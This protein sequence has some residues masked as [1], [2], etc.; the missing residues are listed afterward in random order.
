MPGEKNG[1]L[2]HGARFVLAID[3]ISLSGSRHPET[4]LCRLKSELLAIE[5]IRGESG[6]GKPSIPLSPD[7]S[8]QTGRKS[9]GHSVGIGDAVFHASMVMQAYSDGGRVQLRVRSVGLRRELAAGAIE[10]KLDTIPSHRAW[11]CLGRQ[12]GRPRLYLFMRLQ[13]Q[14]TLGTF[15]A[16][17][18][19]MKPAP[20]QQASLSEFLGAKGGA[21]SK[22][23]T[24]DKE[25]SGSKTEAGG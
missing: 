21:K 10:F 19:T 14:Q 6:S 15:F 9:T 23:S 4:Q 2:P 24:K 17:P 11:T 3:L 7:F 8:L 22:A 13:R 16:K 5:E 18:A 20:A 12:V 25:S 1:W